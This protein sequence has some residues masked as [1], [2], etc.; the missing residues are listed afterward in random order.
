MSTL[1]DT[2]DEVEW[3]EE[4]NEEDKIDLWLGTRID[5]PLKCGKCFP[6]DSDNT[7]E[8]PLCSAKVY[9]LYRERNIDWDWDFS[10]LNPFAGC[11]YTFTTNTTKELCLWQ[12]VVLWARTQSKL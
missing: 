8:M 1:Q 3:E 9:R 10:L 4:G 7:R 11:S 6:N 2:D 12:W 5:F